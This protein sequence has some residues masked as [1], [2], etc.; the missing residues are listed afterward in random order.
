MPRRTTIQ[1]EDMHYTRVTTRKLKYS[2]L[3]FPPHLTVPVF[4]SLHLPVIAH[5]FRTL[6]VSVAKV[7]LLNVMHISPCFVRL[8]RSSTYMRRPWRSCTLRIIFAK[9][10]FNASSKT[11][12]CELGMNGEIGGR[13]DRWRSKQGGMRSSKSA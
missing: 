10:S 1:R 9:G 8:L 6:H 7:R 11:E 4:A 12:G 2:S 3:P 5:K 13:G